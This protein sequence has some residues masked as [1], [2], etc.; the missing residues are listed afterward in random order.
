MTTARMHKVNNFIL[1]SGLTED[2]DAFGLNPIAGHSLSWRDEKKT[3]LGPNN[4]LRAK[5][6]YPENPTKVSTAVRPI[7]TIVPNS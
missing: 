4:T 1:F 7:T 5:L 2:Y 6:W 3:E